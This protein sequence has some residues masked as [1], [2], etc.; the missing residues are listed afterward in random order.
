MGSG[1]AFL[2]LGASYAISSPVVARFLDRNPNTWFYGILATVAILV[3]GLAMLLTG[4][5]PF[6]PVNEIASKRT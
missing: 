6:L 1:F 3:C 2:L 5:A 4:P